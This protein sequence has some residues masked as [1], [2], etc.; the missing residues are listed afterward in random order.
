MPAADLTSLAPQV[1]RAAPDLV[2]VRGL[3]VA[4]RG[5]RPAR[6]VDNV[7]F[8][9]RRGEVLAIVGESGCGKTMTCLAL[10][11]LLPAGVQL[12]GGSARFDGVELIGRRERDLQ[13]LRGRRIAMIFQDP[14]SALNPVH[15]IGDTLARSLMRHRGLD[16]AAADAEACRLLDRVRIPRP[17][18]RMRAFPHELS[19]GMNQR[20]MIALSLTGGPDL[21]IADE[22][23]T[24]LDVTMQ[25]Q[26]LDLLAEIRRDTGLAMILIS[27]DLGVVAEIADRVAVMYCGRLVEE[28]PA[29]V[30]FGAPA[31]PYTAGLVASMP[32]DP[33]AEVIRPA[34]PIRGSVAR[35]ADLPAGCHFHPRCDHAAEPCRRAVPNLV[36]LAPGRK[37]L[38]HNPIGGYPPGQRVDRAEESQTARRAVPAGALVP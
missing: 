33:R 11:G 37:V 13:A 24:A 14:G 35:F 8:S 7:S 3:A 34:P 38:C 22:P 27:H 23:T 6:L 32:P 16:R 36:A 9:L 26:V 20:V 25:S 12:Q 21:L 5:E 2:E 28:G 15:R 30:L 29:R 19:G 4:T 10:I 17:E 1:D 31:H 18:T